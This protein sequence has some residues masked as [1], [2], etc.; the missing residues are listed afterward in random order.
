LVTAKSKRLLGIAGVSL[1][2]GLAAVAAVTYATW[3]NNAV[4]VYLI[5]RRNRE[6]NIRALEWRIT[7]ETEPTGKAFYQAW[8][9]EEKGDLEGAI[10]GFRS[11]RDAVQPGTALHLKSSL[12]LGLAYGRNRQPEEELAIYRGLMERYP[13][14]S[15]LSQATY[16]LRR[17]EREQARRLLDDA[18]AQD[19]RDKSLGS[20]RQL[21]LSL[22]AGLG[23]APGDN[24]SASP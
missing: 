17:G 20:D 10:R 15:R 22:R 14:Q 5:E 21:A 16:H 12:R 18:L 19:E 9:A 4:G 11:L 24:S 2:F 23:P 13:G 3:P 8:L 6:A 1:A 7:Q